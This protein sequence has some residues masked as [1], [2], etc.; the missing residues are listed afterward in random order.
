MTAPARQRATYADLLALPS[1]VT[2]EILG[3]ELHVMPRP[4][5]RHAAA[6]S[7]LGEELGPPFGR[8]RGGPGGWILLDEPELHLGEDVVVPDLAGWR[9]ERMPELP[10]A[11]FLELA[12]DWVCEILSASTARADRVL[13]RRIYTRERVTHYWM[14]DPDA[15]TLEVGRLE[16]ESYRVVLSSADDEKVRAEPFQAIELDLALLW[17]R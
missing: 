12:P 15:R 10:D 13:K 6:S 7:T 4:R 5:T 2:G 3:G 8:G 17:R 1:H 16:G 11:P 14:V 9:R